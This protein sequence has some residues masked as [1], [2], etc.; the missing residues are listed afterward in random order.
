MSWMLDRRLSFLFMLLS[1]MKYFCAWLATCTNS[2]PRCAYC[3]ALFDYQVSCVR[4][5]QDRLLF[6]PKPPWLLLAS[7]PMIV[8]PA[9]QLAR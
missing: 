3:G 1:R 5:L 6:T 7:N 4:G 8:L 2:H 9:H